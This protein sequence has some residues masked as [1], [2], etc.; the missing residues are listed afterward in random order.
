ML[1]QESIE[2]SSWLET[3]TD[4]HSHIIDLAERFR[5]ANL[6][7]TLDHAT[8]ED[9]IK[10]AWVHGAWNEVARACG[11]LYYF[12]DIET[13]YYHT[14]LEDGTK[15]RYVA[16]LDKRKNLIGYYT[17]DGQYNLYIPQ[18]D[19]TTGRVTKPKVRTVSR[20]RRHVVGP[21]SVV[22]YVVLTLHHV[23]ESLWEISRR[24]AK[25]HLMYESYL[26]CYSKAIGSRMIELG[27][28]LYEENL[29][30]LGDDLR[31]LEKRLDDYR[32]TNGLRMKVI[33][34]KL[35][36]TEHAVELPEEFQ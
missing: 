19:E 23:C 33:K 16:D 2:N 32:K 25:K 28:Q 13:T 11:C 21:A 3:E 27:Q 12:E 26:T 29:K 1:V 22:P 14:E 18:I 15:V 30:I 7:D 35:V 36:K 9:I 31:Q 4:C 20:V 6:L 24:S 8:E 10:N 5:S 17:D 34:R